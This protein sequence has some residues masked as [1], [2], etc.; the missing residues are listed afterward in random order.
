MFCRKIIKGQNGRKWTEMDLNITLRY[1]FKRLKA[2][3]IR[4]TIFENAKRL[5]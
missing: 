5:N 4:F 1:L 3:K 2:V